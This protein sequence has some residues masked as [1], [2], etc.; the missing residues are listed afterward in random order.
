MSQRQSSAL[1]NVVIGDLQRRHGLIHVLVQTMV[2]HSFGTQAIT[3]L[4]ALN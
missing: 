2:L 3:P 4:S 1:E